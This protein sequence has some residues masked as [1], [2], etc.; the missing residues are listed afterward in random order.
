[1]DFFYW[2]YLKQ[3]VYSHK[4]RNLND[5]R[6]AIA[7]EIEEMDGSLID[8]SGRI[9]TVT[10]PGSHRHRREAIAKET[11]FSQM[12]TYMEHYHTTIVAVFVD[13]QCVACK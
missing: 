4:L 5:L 2:G 3:K 10:T 12:D 13:L 8:Q 6:E 7:R 11:F 9:C 1:M